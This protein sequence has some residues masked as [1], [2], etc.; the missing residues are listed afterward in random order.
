MAKTIKNT[1]KRAPAKRPAASR[2]PAK[3]RLVAVKPSGEKEGSLV[4][5]IHDLVRQIPKGRVTSYGAIATVL[6]IPNPRMVGR[7]MR[8]G[9]STKRAVPFQR[10]VN[11]AGR[12][13]GDHRSVRKQ[14]LEKEGVKIK[15]DKIIDFKTIFWDPGKE[16]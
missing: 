9:D 8:T 7:A 4:D 6:N 11:S 16:L 5:L 2:A 13:T 14:L 10:V 12:L 1:T 15:G 3:Q